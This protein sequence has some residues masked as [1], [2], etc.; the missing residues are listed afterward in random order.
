MCIEQPHA[1]THTQTQQQCCI[2]FN[3]TMYLYIILYNECDTKQCVVEINDAKGN[4]E[5]E[6]EEAML[7]KTKK[8]CRYKEGNEENKDER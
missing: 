5:S 6:D 1:H 4:N 8:N 2:N 7:S 3:F